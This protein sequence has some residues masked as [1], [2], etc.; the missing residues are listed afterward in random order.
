MSH[1]TNDGK[2]STTHANARFA[3][4]AVVTQARQLCHIAQV[5]VSL[6]RRMVM[7][8]LPCVLYSHRH[9][10]YVTSHK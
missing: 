10:N 1:R 9:D 6:A 2:P 3:V 7:H 5:T 8:G 4:R